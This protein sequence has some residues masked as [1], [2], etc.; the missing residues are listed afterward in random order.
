MKRGGFYSIILF[1]VLGAQYSNAYQKTNNQPKEE[2]Y[3]FLANQFYI[4]EK[5][6]IRA[7]SYANKYLIKAKKEKDTLKIADGYYFLSSISSHAIS[8]QYSDSIISITKNLNS[9]VYPTY[10]YYNKATIYY[11]IGDFKQAFDYFLKMNLEAEKYNN[12]YLLYASKKSIGIIKGMLG[13]NKTALKMLI[14]CYDYYSKLKESE[15]VNYLETLFALSESY[16]L[17]RITD[18][19]TYINKF[20]YKEAILLNNEKFK[21]YF[22]LNEGINQYNNENYSI[23]KDSLEKAL[24]EFKVNGD[25]ANLGQ[26]HF[27]LGKTLSQLGYLDKS[28]EEHIKVGEIFEE[29]PQ[30]IPESRESYEILINHYK[31]I[32]DKDTQLQYIERLI[33]VDS[34]L[35]N[36]YKYLIKNVVQKYDTPKLLSEKQTII[37]SLK[38]HKKS[39]LIMILSLTSVSILSIILLVL[40]YRKKKNYKKRF[41]ELYKSTS[42]N[43]TVTTQKIN[44]PV[45]QEHTLGISKDIVN[46]II[47]DLEEFEQSREF[48]KSNITTTDLA[49]KMNTNSKY[50]SKVVNHYKQKSF[51]TYI[52]ELRIDYCIEKLKTDKK[53][54]NYTIKAIAREVGFNSA[55]AFSKSFYKIKGIQPSYFI[56]ELEKQL[57]NKN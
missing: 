11:N 56:K 1:L 50:L 55:D 21:Y 49:K 22:I 15:P 53:F 57:N 20:G 30:I 42:T 6:S 13:E 45:K 14:D 25:K 27:Y 41:D 36:N 40:N 48:T 35:N 44:K 19:A 31:Q 24:I 32:N 17:N 26:T 43:S 4:H 33:H 7:A 28:I 54:M 52:N 38:T 47:K 16:N 10:A 29:I 2:E 37:D 18:S 51:S 46:E 8:N 3:Q 5:D 23:A 39:S 12:E 9:P 34:I